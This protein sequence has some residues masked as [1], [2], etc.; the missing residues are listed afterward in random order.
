[1]LNYIVRRVGYAFVTLIFVAIVGFIIIELPPGSYLDF[2]LREL[3]TAGGDISLDQ[4]A[5]L[6][7]RYGVNDPVIVKFWKWFSQLRP[8][9]LWVVLP[10]RKGR[11]RTAWGTD[12]A[13]RWSWRS[14]R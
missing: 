1:M 8:G 7:K 9:R 13:S 4:I 2:R 14:R 5:S 12:W 6:E 10:L 11:W 3:R